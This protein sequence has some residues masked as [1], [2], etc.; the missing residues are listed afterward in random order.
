MLDHA[1]GSVTPVSEVDE[2]GTTISFPALPITLARS[3]TTD[4]RTGGGSTSGL[5]TPRGI[6]EETSSKTPLRSVS[7][8][9]RSGG[10]L[11][12]SVNALPLPGGA[13]SPGSAAPKTI[14]VSASSTNGTL[15]FV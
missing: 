4:G 11:G 9:K 7:A 2:I 10:S 8:T 1:G 5:V 3:R 14:P 12:E 15:T 6:A 13:P